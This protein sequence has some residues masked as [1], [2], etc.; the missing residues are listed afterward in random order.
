MK[1]INIIG[2]A[3][4]ASFAISMVASASASATLGIFECTLGSGTTNL[5]ANCLEE[6]GA[7]HTVKVITGATFTG[8]A[9]GA[10][11]LTAGTKKIECAA[12]TN[13][14]E[15]TSLTEDKGTI[16][17]SGCKETPSGV[18]CE[19]PGG[20]GSGILLVAISSRI[21]SYTQNAT[22]KAGLLLSVRNATGE[23]KIEIEC[24]GTKVK[25]YGSVVGS[26][27]PEDT[28][29]LSFTAKYVVTN[30]VQEISEL[31]TNS[32]LRAKFGGGATE[33]ATQEGEA[34]LDFTLK[35]EVMG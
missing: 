32:S 20:V 8:K 13:T 11:I 9:V 3:L 35:V 12:G 7:E 6:A 5:G 28:A 33:K 1:L 26:I 21:V 17:F 16:K 23:N 18:K 4:L 15:I 24:A 29:S 25:V 22:L 31:S 14:G 34:L 27:T 10:T 19:A 2:L 30:G